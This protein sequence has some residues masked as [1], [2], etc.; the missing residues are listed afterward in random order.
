MIWPLL[1]GAMVTMAILA[2]SYGVLNTLAGA[3]ARLSTLLRT[4]KELG[5]SEEDEIMA[6]LNQAL[7]EVNAGLSFP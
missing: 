7:K 5:G 6:A 1:I 4:Q 3:A 2:L